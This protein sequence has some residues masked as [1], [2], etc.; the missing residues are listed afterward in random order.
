MSYELVAHSFCI[1]SVLKRSAGFVLITCQ[2][3]IPVVS[4]AMKIII[5]TEKTNVNVATPLL[6]RYI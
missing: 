5:S 4:N 2:I 6:I 1:H 3:F